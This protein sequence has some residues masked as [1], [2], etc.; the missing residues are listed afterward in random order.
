MADTENPEL[1]EALLRAISHPLRHRLLGML[2]GRVASPNEL[3]RELGLP[4][5]RVSYHIRLLS[6]L[7]AIELVRTEPRRGA[8]EHF[9]RAVTTVWFNEGDWAKLPRSAR[10]GLLGQNLQQIFGDVTAAADGG[11]FE[12]ESSLV[13]RATLALDEAG[14]REVSSLLRAAFDR[15]RELSGKS[16]GVSAELSV[17]LFERRA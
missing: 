12:H 13:L 15:A 1:D 16:S 4:L 5:G 9:Y 10:R 2:D 11:G 7:G 3:A 14:M 8:L 6:D 17:L